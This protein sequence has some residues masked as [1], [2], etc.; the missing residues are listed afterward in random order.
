MKFLKF[1]DKVAFEAA[2]LPF[3]SVDVQGNPA[4]PSYIGT[5]A[6]DVL[7][8]I[9]K[10]SGKFVTDADG[11]RTPVMEALPGFHVNLSGDC[12]QELAAFLIPPPAT[13]SRVFA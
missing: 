5:S 1:A 7:G 4:V 6:V 8:V 9:Y 3:M 2:F 12:P 10:P 11:L 13:P